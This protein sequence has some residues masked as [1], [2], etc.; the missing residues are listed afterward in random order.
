MRRSVVTLLASTNS[1][2][3]CTAYLTL[4]DLSFLRAALV[5]RL[6]YAIMRSGFGGWWVPWHRRRSTL[7]GTHCRKLSVDN[8]SNE[9]TMPIGWL[10]AFRG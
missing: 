6:G 2:G 9:G 3:N 1:L 8:W 7:G 10:Y 4:A 5:R